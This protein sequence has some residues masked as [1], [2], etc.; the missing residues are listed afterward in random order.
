MRDEIIDKIK[1]TADNNPT[2]CV[3]GAGNGGLAMAGYLAIN[4]FSVNIWTRNKGK[5][6]KH[7]QK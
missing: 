5:K 7:L 6:L 4:G 2:F 3:I 1:H